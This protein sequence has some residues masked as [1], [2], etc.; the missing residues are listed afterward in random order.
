MGKPV[1]QVEEW[2]AKELNA[3]HADKKNFD[4]FKRYSFGRIFIFSIYHI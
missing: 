1:R 2:C 4:S 3:G